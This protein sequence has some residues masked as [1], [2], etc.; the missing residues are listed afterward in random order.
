MEDDELMSLAKMG[1]DAEDFIRSP[2]GKF[3]IKK[4]EAEINDATEDLIMADPDD[5]K[6]NTEIRNRIHVARMFVVWLSE[7]VNIGRVAHDQMR[8]MEENE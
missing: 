4:A 1:I 3:L 7:S 8:E 6:A 5:V 2:L